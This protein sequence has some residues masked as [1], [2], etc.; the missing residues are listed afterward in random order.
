[1]KENPLRTFDQVRADIWGLI[2][3]TEHRQFGQRR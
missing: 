1:M 3:P 2:D